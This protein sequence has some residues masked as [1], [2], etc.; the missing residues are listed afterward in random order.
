[1]QFPQASVSLLAQLQAAAQGFPC[2]HLEIG[3]IDWD[4]S[5]TIAHADPRERNGF[6]I[7]PQT[8]LAIQRFRLA[9]MSDAEKSSAILDTL[10]SMA[11]RRP[12]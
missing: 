3:D 5:L 2:E 7:V 9:V 12:F 6:R 4:F 1:M 11:R 10:S 8:H